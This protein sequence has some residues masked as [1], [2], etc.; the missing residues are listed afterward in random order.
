[1]ISSFRLKF[2]L[3]NISLIKPAMNQVGLVEINCR[4][5][6]HSHIEKKIPK[7]ALVCL[8]KI[9]AVIV[10]WILVIECR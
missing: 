3:D 2:R 5:F 10:F 8:E 7:E 6:F 9:I 4:I 1:M